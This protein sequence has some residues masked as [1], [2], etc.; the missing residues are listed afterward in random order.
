MMKQRDRGTALRALAS[1][2]LALPGLASSSWANAPAERPEA[3]ARYSRYV[4][5][6]LPGHRIAGGNTSERY[7]IDTL[8]FHYGTPWG[9]RSDL[10]F[11]LVFETMSGASPIT[12]QPGPQGNQV[13]MSGATIEEE[14]IDISAGSNYYFDSGRGGAR[15]G[16]STENDYLAINLGFD[17]ERNVNDDMT[18]LLGGVGMSFDS[19]D[20]TGGG[21]IAFPNRPDSEK[22]QSY[23]VFGGI[24]QILSRTAALQATASY[25]YS[26]GYL[27]DPYK[28]AVV[29]GTRRPDT[30]P[31]L[32]HQLAFLVRA[33]KHYE[34]V[35]G[36]LHAD[37]QYAF[38]DWGINA[39]TVEAAW[40]QTLFEVLKL[41]P[42]FRYF[43]QSQADF[44]DTSFGGAAAPQF[45]SSDYRL[46][47]YG[48][49]SYGIKAETRF[50]GWFKTDW[51]VAFAYDRY[52][53][54]ADLA[55]GGV[56]T[57]N[58][59]LV[60]YHLISVRLIGRF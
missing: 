59:G 40:H 53:T 2:A 43:S 52:V 46:S 1:S 49:L 10:D 30:R 45:F 35:N 15:F 11:N 44:Y 9:K 37:V 33:R 6:D 47:P 29:L 56:E 60:A 7:T 14:R 31:E 36:T 51:D 17:G 22:K 8:Q 50:R 3:H 39:V 58:P 24:A 34:Q 57:E 41:V 23:Q 4:E 38:D 27:S 54:D 13:V 12:V 55:L 19:I 28:E 48:A 25:R 42:Q 18:T 5:D 16:V 26:T 32:R 20:P 21:A